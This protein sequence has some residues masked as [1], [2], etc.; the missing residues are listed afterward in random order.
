MAQDTSP[1]FPVLDRKAPV[2]ERIRSRRQKNSIGGKVGSKVGELVLEEDE[3]EKLEQAQEI[4]EEFKQSLSSELGV[5]PEIVDDK[6]V[7]EVVALFGTL[8]E[9]DILISSPDDV[10]TEEGETESSDEDEE[11]SDDSPFSQ[12]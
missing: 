6:V 12:Q 4:G 5:P 7:N 2:I 11:D 8:T 1:I 3:E 10:S 9:E